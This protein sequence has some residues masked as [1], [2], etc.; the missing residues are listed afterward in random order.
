MKIRILS[1]FLFSILTTNS[2]ADFEFVPQ[3]IKSLLP[4]NQSVVSIKYGKYSKNLSS[5]A[6]VITI[7][8]KVEPQ[9]TDSF[10]NLYKFQRNMYVLNQTN[11]KWKIITQNNEL[12]KPKPL[13]SDMY[14]IDDIEFRNSYVNGKRS[15]AYIS[16]TPIGT[17]QELKGSQGTYSLTFSDTDQKSYITEENYSYDDPLDK[18]RHCR[19]SREYKNNVYEFSTFKPK[20]RELVLP[21]IKN[22]KCYS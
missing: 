15:T 4:K 17:D 11:G 12:L 13:A 16:I 9:I 7:D 19:I 1:I 6:V 3:S 5:D 2:F 14:R 21:A 10:E 18:N 8:E 22:K 20:Q